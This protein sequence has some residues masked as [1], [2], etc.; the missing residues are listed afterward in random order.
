M[1]MLDV[2]M[3]SFLDYDEEFFVEFMDE[4]LYNFV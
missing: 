1:V 4:E 3:S 2:D